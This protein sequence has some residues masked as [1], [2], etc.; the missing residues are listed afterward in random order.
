M[1]TRSFSE[2]VA[3]RVEAAITQSGET[4]LGVALATG[5]PRSTLARRLSGYSP[6][7]VSELSAIATALGVDVLTLVAP[8]PTVAAS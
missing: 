1:D 7:T 4:Q 5:I 6:F 8:A 3:K 2:I